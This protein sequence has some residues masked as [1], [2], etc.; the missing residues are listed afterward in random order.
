MLAGGRRRVVGQDPLPESGNGEHRCA[1][2]FGLD[3]RQRSCQT[4][5]AMSVTLSVPEAAA[6]LRVSQRTIWRRIRSGQLPASR[7]G[8]RV[9]VELDAH[10]QGA[11]RV[12]E[13]TAPYG[14]S[15]TWSDPET[16]GPWPYTAEARQ[17]QRTTLLAQRRAAVE[18]MRAIARESRPDPD[19]LTVVD[20]LREL[21]DPDWEPQD[22]E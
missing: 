22:D 17:R 13:A 12:S 10:S 2:A 8:R 18:A 20:Y 19:G 11:S 15:D 1:V 9:R 6:Y 14:P 4:V 16:D 3:R 7:L 5:K 21:R